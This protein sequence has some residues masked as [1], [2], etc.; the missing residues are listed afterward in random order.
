MILVLAGLKNTFYLSKQNWIDLKV[1]YYKDH[2]ENYNTLFVG[3]SQTCNHIDPEVFDSVAGYPVKSF[4]LGI[5]SFR[6]QHIF[7]LTEHILSLDPPGLEYL[8]VEFS[9]VKKHLFLGSLKKPAPAYWFNANAFGFTF[10]YLWASQMPVHK[11]LYFSTV[12]IL[13]YLKRSAY[14]LN[15]WKQAGQLPVTLSDFDHWVNESGHQ[16]LDYDRFISALAADTAGLGRHSGQFAAVARRH[17]K[18]LNDPRSIQEL[19]EKISRLL[20][21]DAPPEKADA[22]YLAQVR[23]LQELADAKNVKLIFL[24]Q[25]LDEDLAAV[26]R[27][28]RQ[29]DHPL[30]I[31]L[32][33]PAKYP[34]W[35]DLDYSFDGNHMNSKGARLYSAALARSFLELINPSHQPKGSD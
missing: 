28:Y 23:A 7:Y 13:N 12:Y 35:Y 4:N 21:Q 9:P 5:H 10:R 3:S 11:K 25:N 29:L 6:A 20:Q 27:T 18:L 19:K 8:V 14:N 33:D 31:D 2:H 24:M 26:I 22:I 16:P 1:R 34:E 17:E 15:P 30:K 32:I